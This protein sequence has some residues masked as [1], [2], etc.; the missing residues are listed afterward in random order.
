MTPQIYAGLPDLTKYNF[1]NKLLDLEKITPEIVINQVCN[2]F[3]TSISN[4]TGKSQKRDNAVPR[5]IAMFLIKNNTKLSLKKIGSY[6]SNR[7]H[8]TVIHSIELI[9]DLYGLDKQ[10]T[11]KMNKVIKSINDLN[12]KS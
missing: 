12:A 3:K 6:F 10:L 9:N 1:K 8:S 11:D 5:Q 2:I 7:D 4:I